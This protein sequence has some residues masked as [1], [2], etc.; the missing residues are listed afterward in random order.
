MGEGVSPGLFEQGEDLIPLHAGKALK[1]IFDGI[2]RF[3]V[4]EEAL[5]RYAGSPEDRLSTENRW[6]L[7]H[8]RAHGG[9]LTDKKIIGELRWNP[10]LPTKKTDEREA[11]RSFLR[12]EEAA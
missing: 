12:Q 2:A 10:K 9:S 11:H 7:R 8:D 6:I 4:I 3:Q 5:H 1:E